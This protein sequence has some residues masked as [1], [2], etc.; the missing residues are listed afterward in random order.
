MA[1][2]SDRLAKRDEREIEGLP[3]GNGGKEEE[4]DEGRRRGAVKDLWRETDRGK[5]GEEEPFGRKEVHAKVSFR[6]VCPL[7]EAEA[8]PLPPSPPSVLLAK[9][10]CLIFLFFFLPLLRQS[11]SLSSLYQSLPAKGRETT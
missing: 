7:S 1:P 8:L 5:E 3:K 9:S 2:R 4:A 11:P 6:T 10:L